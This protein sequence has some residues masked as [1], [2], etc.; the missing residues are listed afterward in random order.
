MPILKIQRGIEKNWHIFF[1]I[2]IVKCQRNSKGFDLISPG[3]LAVDVDTVAYTLK[4]NPTSLTGTLNLTYCI[5][6]FELLARLIMTSRST[7]LFTE[8]INKKVG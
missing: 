1:S 3:H 6:L 2:V 4:D 8:P 5:I 7:T